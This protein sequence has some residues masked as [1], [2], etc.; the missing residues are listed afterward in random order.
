[1]ICCLGFREEG[2]KEERKTMVD[3]GELNQC[4]AILRV[5]VGMHHLHRHIW[6]PKTFLL[7]CLRRY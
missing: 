2:I 6:F 3:M 4:L 7:I 1:M 5:R